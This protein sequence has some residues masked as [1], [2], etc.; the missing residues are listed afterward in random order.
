[1][2]DTYPECRRSNE[3]CESGDQCW[4]PLSGGMQT[5][6][7]TGHQKCL[8][9][10]FFVSAPT[11]LRTHHIAV[12]AEPR[13]ASLTE[14]REV[15]SPCRMETH[16]NACHEAASPATAHLRASRAPRSDAAPRF[17]RDGAIIS[18]TRRRTTR[19]RRACALELRVSRMCVCILITESAGNDQYSFCVRC[20]KNINAQSMLNKISCVC[21]ATHAL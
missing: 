18:G 10:V 20:N 14:D 5:N 8:V 13:V 21:R 19:A 16:V 7:R 2:M 6:A 17:P 11:D 15:V 1:M 12:R 3:Q 9:R 4:S